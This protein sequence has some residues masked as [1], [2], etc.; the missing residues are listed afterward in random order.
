M[1]PALEARRALL[2][3]EPGLAASLRDIFHQP[4]FSGWQ[5]VPAE[6]LEQARFLHQHQSAHVL[7]ADETRMPTPDV[8]DVAWLGGPVPLPVLLLVQGDL[9]GQVLAHVPLARHW[10]PIGPALK[11]PVLLAGALHQ[12]AELTDLRRHT[13]ATDRALHVSRRQ[14][15]QLVG[16][17]WRTLPA[18]ADTGWLSQRHLL[19]RLRQEVHRAGRYGA[20]LTVILADVA[21]VAGEPDPL[22]NWLADRMGRVKRFSDLAG[23]YGPRGFLVILVNTPQAG[24]EACCRRLHQVLTQPADPAEP[25]LRPGQLHFGFASLSPTVSTSARLLGLAEQHLE[26]AQTAGRACDSAL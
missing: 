14:I 20:P 6:S 3:V 24:G 11:Y 10:L 1:L 22:L 12:A 15:D 26:A 7:L 9:P 18:D 17:L 19:Q 2:I 5:L 8:A 13:R 21:P 16:L 25:H 4:L 23:Q